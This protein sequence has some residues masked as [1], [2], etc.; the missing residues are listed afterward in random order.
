[1]AVT[2]TPAANLPSALDPITCIA[3]EGNITTY[4]N[5]HVAGG[6]QDDAY[7]FASPISPGDLVA[8]SEDTANTYSATRGVPVVTLATATLPAFGRCVS[9]ERQVKGRNALTSDQ[10]TW[11]TM[12]SS[13]FYRICNIEPLWLIGAA[14]ADTDGGSTAIEP[15]A[16]VIWDVS[17]DG[18]KDN[19]TTMTGWVALT[20][21]ANTSADTIIVGWGANPQLT[22]DHAGMSLVA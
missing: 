17:A 8:L 16:P 4:D 21:S 3:K 10:S 18:F 19:G 13:K 7:S 22:S 2:I 15:G 9:I 11:S 14:E 1:M 12:L 6:E 5:I 20:Y